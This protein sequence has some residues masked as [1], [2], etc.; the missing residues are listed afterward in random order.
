MAFFFGSLRLV[1][2]VFGVVGAVGVV[3]VDDTAED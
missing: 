3:G 2:P 1:E